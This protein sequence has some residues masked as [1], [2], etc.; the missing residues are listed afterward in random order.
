ML[1][2]EIGFHG[3]RFSCVFSFLHIPPSLVETLHLIFPLSLLV[4]L[5]LAKV[6]LSYVLLQRWCLKYCMALVFL[7]S[8]SFDLYRR[9]LIFNNSP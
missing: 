5:R 1:C 8:P 6:Y 9:T 4:S 3:L 7:L 2:L